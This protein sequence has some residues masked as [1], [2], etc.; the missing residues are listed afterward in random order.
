MTH[1][2]DYEKFER[3]IAQFNSDYSDRF[4]YPF[5]YFDGLFDED[6]IKEINKEIDKKSFKLDDRNIDGEE[7]KIRSD[8]QDNED[9]PPQSKRIFDV[10]NGGK[11]LELVSKLTGIEGLISDPYYD[12]GGINIIENQG[13]LA[14]HL[15]GTTQHRM[16]L[17]RRVNAILFVNDSWDE[18]WNGYHEQWDYLNKNMSPFDSEQDWRCV[19][20]ILPRRNRMLIFTT[21]DHSWHGHAGVLDVPEGVQR[22]S[23][24]TYFYTAT[25]PES[26]L[27]YDSPHRALFINNDI[28]LTDR[29]FED[30]EV[31]L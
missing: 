17:C 24:I 11:F 9:L 5:A 3:Q 2:F 10:L 25:R 22:R 18:S 14:V 21:N 23:L 8:F 4:P 26:D 27:L 12:G 13:T 7:V 19:R 28:T 30:V 15:D 16:Q 6:V 31:V 29:A 20:K 1:C